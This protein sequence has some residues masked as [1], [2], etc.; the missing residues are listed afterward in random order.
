[1]RDNS[2]SETC[3]FCGKIK[4][5]TPQVEPVGFV[6]NKYQPIRGWASQLPLV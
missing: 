3:G 4:V 6:V 5:N 1:M 2:F